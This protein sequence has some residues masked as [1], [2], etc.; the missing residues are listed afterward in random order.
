MTAAGRTIMP[1]PKAAAN[2]QHGDSQT[3]LC[4]S[5]AQDG[6]KPACARVAAPRLGARVA[7]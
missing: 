1:E 2:G 7:V 5:R 4:D 3:T 6:D